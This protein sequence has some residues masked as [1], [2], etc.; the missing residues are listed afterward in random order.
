MTGHRQWVTSLSWEPLHLNGSC[1]RL[2]SGSKVLC[3]EDYM[4]R[5]VTVTNTTW[6]CILCHTSCC[7]SF[8]CC[9]DATI[10]IWDTVLC[11]CLLILSSHLQGLTS[12]RW[13]GEGWIYSASQDRTI[14]VWRTTDVNSLW[15]TLFATWYTLQRIKKYLLCLS[16]FFPNMWFLIAIFFTCLYGFLR[17]INEVFAQILITCSNWVYI[18]RALCVALCKVMVTGSMCLLLTLIT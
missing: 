6:Y 7:F 11:Q 10:R 9:Q 8:V 14:K 5:F 15:K 1:K 4:F 2:A 18:F 3:W 16:C 17:W 13:S 12:L